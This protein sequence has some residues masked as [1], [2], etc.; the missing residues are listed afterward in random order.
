MFRRACWIG[1]CEW[2]LILRE[3]AWPIAFTLMPLG[4]ITVLNGA[5]SKWLR[6]NVGLHNASGAELSVGGQTALFSIMLLANFGK[7]LYRDCSTG[8]WDRT[9]ASFASPFEILIGKLGAT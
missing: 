6:F 1:R 4:L 2:Q 8:V 3:P 5:F 9:R 7:F